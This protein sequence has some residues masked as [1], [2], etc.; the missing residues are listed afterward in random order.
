MVFPDSN[1]IRCIVKVMNLSLYKIHDFFIESVV[2]S[3][4]SRIVYR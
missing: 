4:A 2:I 3:T 1:Y